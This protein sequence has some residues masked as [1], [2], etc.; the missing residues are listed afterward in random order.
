MRISSSLP[1]PSTSCESPLLHSIPLRSGLIHTLVFTHLLKA[2]LE[3][4]IGRLLGTRDRDVSCGVQS[5]NHWIWS[6]S[7]GNLLG[8]GIGS[9]SSDED[10]SLRK[11]KVGSSSRNSDSGNSD[12]GRGGIGDCLLE[13]R[14]DCRQSRCHYEGQQLDGVHV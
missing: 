14:G 9:S 3:T 5:R 7:S 12:S 2:S 13:H 4:T 10:L 11:D 6:D 1:R 8:D